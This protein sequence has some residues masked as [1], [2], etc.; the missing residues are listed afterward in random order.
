MRIVKAGMA[1]VILAVS[2]LTPLMACQPKSHSN[3]VFDL[4]D[5]MHVFAMKFYDDTTF[6]YP[7]SG[8]YRQGP[9]KELVWEFS[10]I[11]SEL[12]PDDRISADG[13]YFVA[14]NFLF[15]DET[16]P[17]KT[18]VLSIYDKGNLV[19]EFSRDSFVDTET[20]K[21]YFFDNY[22]NKLGLWCE[23]ARWAYLRYNTLENQIKIRVV[24]NRTVVIDVPSAE[25]LYV[26]EY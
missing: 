6:E 1:I 25:I 16:V 4:E 10:G 17:E 13:R 15:L 20:L 23:P 19:K 7:V 24:R 26:D 5:G 18:V 22:V 9:S 12:P 2:Y 14:T 21:E 11:S 3:Y 8:V